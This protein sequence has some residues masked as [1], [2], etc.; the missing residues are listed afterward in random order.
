MSRKVSHYTMTQCCFIQCG[1]YLDPSLLWMFLLDE[2]FVYKNALNTVNFVHLHKMQVNLLLHSW[3]CKIFNPEIRLKS[4]V[5][6][7]VSAGPQSFLLTSTKLG[8]VWCLSIR[9]GAGLQDMVSGLWACATSTLL[10]QANLCKEYSIKR[11]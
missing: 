6:C 9:G 3:P 1:W 5:C 2:Q 10:L 4:T 7:S 11:T 8:R